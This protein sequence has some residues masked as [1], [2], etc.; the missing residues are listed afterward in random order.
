MRGRRGMCDQGWTK[1]TVLSFLIIHAFKVRCP[2]HQGRGALGALLQAYGNSHLMASR[3]MCT[4][5][6]GVSNLSGLG[7]RHRD[8]LSIIVRTR[9]YR[10]QL[11]QLGQDGR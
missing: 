5:L 6:E 3:G 1:E 10:G 4:H 7:F 11:S 9:V 2:T 8:H